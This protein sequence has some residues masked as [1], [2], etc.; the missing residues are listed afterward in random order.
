MRLGDWGLRVGYYWTPCRADE[1]AIGVLAAIAWRSRDKRQWIQTHLQY[2]WIA[3][4]VSCALL[5]AMLRWLVAP[6]SFVLTTFGR[7]VFEVFYCCLM[8]ILLLDKTS[9]IAQVCRWRLLREMGQVSYCVYV[10]HNEIDVLAHKIMR[11]DAARF[12]SWPA[13]GVTL[14]A[15]ATTIIIAKFSWRFFEGPLIRRGHAFKY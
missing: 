13:I 6:N 9:L 10:I 5:L 14:V 8:L 2:V 15:F 11:H 12:D 1:L 3:L 7:P 4:S